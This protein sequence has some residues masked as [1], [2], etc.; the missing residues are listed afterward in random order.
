MKFRWVYAGSPY[1]TQCQE[2]PYLPEYSAFN[3]NY[4][5]ECGQSGSSTEIQLLT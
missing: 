2:S 4:L 3:I 1:L 5:S